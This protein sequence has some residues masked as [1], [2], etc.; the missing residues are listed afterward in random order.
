M[1]R[2]LSTIAQSG[3]ILINCTVMQSVSIKIF[4]SYT[5]LGKTKENNG[6]KPKPSMKV[7]K[8]NKKICIG[9]KCV[10]VHI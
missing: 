10:M 1:Q 8:S 9:A 6:E 3:L 5:A 2:F 7:L 4:Y